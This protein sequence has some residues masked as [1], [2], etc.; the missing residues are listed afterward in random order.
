[1]CVYVCAY[2]CACMYAC[3]CAH[4]SF[5]PSLPVN[6]LYHFLHS[7]DLIFSYNRSLSFFF[8]LPLSHHQLTLF[9]IM[10]VSSDCRWMQ[11]I[12]PMSKVRKSIAC[13]TSL[14]CA[15]LFATVSSVP[16]P[17]CAATCACTR[18]FVPSSVLSATKHFPV[19]F[20]NLSI[21]KIWIDK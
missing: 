20:P 3:M 10:M 11:R 6:T 7:L 15:A 21:L 8:F 1:M 13:V 16:Y 2:M 14:V 19:R 5:I 12:L 4:T 18:G 9:F 17:I